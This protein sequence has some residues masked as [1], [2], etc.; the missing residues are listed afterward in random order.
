MDN[1]QLSIINYQFPTPHTLLPIPCSLKIPN[2]N[3][4]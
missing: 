3:F 2:I 4:R 1:E